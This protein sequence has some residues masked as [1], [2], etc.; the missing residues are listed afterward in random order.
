MFNV[1][2]LMIKWVCLNFGGSFY[3][4]ELGIMHV[5]SLVLELLTGGV[6][7]LLATA[8]SR[9]YKNIFQCKNLV[10]EFYCYPEDST[11]LREESLFLG[12]TFF[13]QLW[14]RLKQ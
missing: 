8:L 10:K 2:I 9:L 6:I 3:S 13:D 11:L 1:K 12:K 5:D 14:L 7:D 4:Y